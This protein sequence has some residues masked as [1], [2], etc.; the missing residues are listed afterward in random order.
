MGWMLQLVPF[1]RSA[2]VATGNAD[3]PT[4]VHAV[5]A[6]HDT[7]DRTLEVSALDGTGVGWIVQLV[8]FQPSATVPL[9]GLVLASST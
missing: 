8:P 1:Q 5:R 7:P 3:P 6:A 4:A 2:K 9:G